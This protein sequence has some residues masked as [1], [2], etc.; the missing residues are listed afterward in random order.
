MVSTE[1]APAG[2]EV[3]SKLTVTPAGG[4]LTVSPTGWGLPLV[5]AVLMVAE[6]DPPASTVTE[7]G[8]AAIEK[9]SGGG[10]GAAGL[11]R[12][13]P[14]AQYI[15]FPKAAPKLW[16]PAPA[17]CEPLTTVT[18]LVPVLLCCGLTV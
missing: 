12:A 8:A 18:G 17:T 15:V 9:S 1:L 13:T 7:D 16:A 2:T 6:P 10:G 3:W 4:V 11:N 14:A 5:T